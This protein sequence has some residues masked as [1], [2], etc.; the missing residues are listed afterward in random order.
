MNVERQN[1]ITLPRRREETSKRDYGRLLIVAGSVGYTGAPALAARAA[2]RGGA[3]LVF[4][5]V[6][7]GIWAVEAVK[8]DEAMPF[9]LPEDEAGRLSGAAL[10]ELLRRAQAA[11]V[12][13]I[14][15]GLGRS[16]ALA[17][18]VPALVRKA[19]VPV[20]ADADALWALSGDPAAL[21]GAAG[22]VVLTPHAGEFRRL[23]GNPAGDR[24]G[25]ARAF[26]RKHR[27]TLVLKGHETVAAF[28][29]GDYYVN[30][31]G[32]A[33]MAKGGSGDVLAGL[34]GAML[35]QLNWADAVR[36]AIWLHGRAG[37]LCAARLGEYGMTPS[38]LIGAL[39][40]AMKEIT[41]Q[42]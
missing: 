28:P 2:V 10:A 24:I 11:S 18:L 1:P 16:P 12:L 38:D 21:D 42:E 7:A 35:C 31:T 3:G 15:P 37:D 19:G 33:G 20:V 32:N 27:C 36:A 17:D 9:P 34:M 4:L 40:E 13:V 22:P 6:P 23:G 30:H 41:E 8:N 5:G 26:A 14:G 29:D 39:P 25:E